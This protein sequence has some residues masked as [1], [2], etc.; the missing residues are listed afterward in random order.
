MLGEKARGSLDFKAAHY[1]QRRCDCGDGANESNY[2]RDNPPVSALRFP[3]RH[4]PSALDSYDY[5][6]DTW[7]VSARFRAEIP[8]TRK[9]KRRPLDQA[10]RLRQSMKLWSEIRWWGIQDLSIR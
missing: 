8:T 6:F 5:N 2:N 1:V 10:A 7:Q 3:F 9:Q 4:G